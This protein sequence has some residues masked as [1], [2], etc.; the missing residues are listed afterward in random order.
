MIHC[1][2]D[3][4]ISGRAWANQCTRQT[5]AT[6][7]EGGEDALVVGKF[8]R[9]CFRSFPRSRSCRYAAGIV[10]P[11]VEGATWDLDMPDESR[12]SGAVV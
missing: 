6:S 3:K 12:P 10:R 4:H 7:P 1:A 9:K 5:I 8:P 11:T 2:W